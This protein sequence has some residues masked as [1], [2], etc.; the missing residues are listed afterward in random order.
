[1]VGSATF[2]DDLKKTETCSPQA[3]ALAKNL[4]DP[5]TVEMLTKI[6]KAIVGL[7]KWVSA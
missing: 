3:A 1:M 4:I 6:N 2:M 7:Y 5:L